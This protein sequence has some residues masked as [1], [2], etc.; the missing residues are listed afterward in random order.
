MNSGGT[1]S[2]IGTIDPATTTINSGGVLA[3]GNATNPTGTLAI[4]GNLVFNAGSTYSIGLT[5][6]AHSL[7]T[8]AGALTINNAATVELSPHLGNYAASSLPSLRRPPG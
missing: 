7:T 8:V 4:A 3:P 1:L 5:P 2:G 6:T